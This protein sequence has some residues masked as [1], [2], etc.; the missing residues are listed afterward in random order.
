MGAAAFTDCT[1]TPVADAYTR[2]ALVSPGDVSAS[3][4]MAQSSVASDS[5]GKSHSH[6]PTEKGAD[7][8]GPGRMADAVTDNDAR[9]EGSESV[10]DELRETIASAVL[11][12]DSDA[13]RDARALLE[14]AGAPDA[15]PVAAAVLLMLSVA[16]ALR[17]RCGDADSECV[18][19]GDTVADAHPEAD[20]LLD[21]EREAVALLDAAGV[22]DSPGSDGLGV[23]VCSCVPLM[24]PAGVPDAN[25]A[26]PESDANAEGSV[27]EGD[28]V[29]EP[30]AGRDADASSDTAAE[31][32]A[33]TAGVADSDAKPE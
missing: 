28:T 2:V 19:D 13:A 23:R 29:S 6:T 9:G 14:E 5:P 21:G 32:D 7:A 3:P 1:D 33:D 20:T 24:E 22:S 27:A 12:G 16:L 10:G 31:R 25:D 8:H 26:E 15:A 18:T 30:L 11:A 4:V 17:D